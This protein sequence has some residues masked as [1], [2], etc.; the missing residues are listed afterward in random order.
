LPKGCRSTAFSARAPHLAQPFSRD[1]NVAGWGL[2]GPTCVSSTS[3]LTAGLKPL[4]IRKSD[5]KRQHTRSRSDC[6]A[7][8]RRHQHPEI[9]A[10]TDEPGTVLWLLASDLPMQYPFI[11]KD[12]PVLR[13][14]ESRMLRQQLSSSSRNSMPV[15]SLCPPTES[16]PDTC[17][18]ILFQHPQ[19]QEWPALAPVLPHPLP[20]ET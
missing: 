9:I 15:L 14:Q 12:R 20:P 11:T 8:N 7:R 5:W 4:H 3:Q 19:E 17:H 2:S 18:Q 1:T 6:C 16:V 13:V 10:D